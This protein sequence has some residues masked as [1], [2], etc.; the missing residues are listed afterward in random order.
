MVVIVCVIV[1]ITS[2]AAFVSVPVSVVWTVYVCC[3][4]PGTE[5]EISL[6]SSL[7][8]SGVMLKVESGPPATNRS[9]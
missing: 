9:W 2:P 8:N 1:P 7:V 5:L 6:S 4:L 3:P